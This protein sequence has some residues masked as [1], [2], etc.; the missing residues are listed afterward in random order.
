V[1]QEHPAVPAA[2][3][4]LEVGAEL[5]PRAIERRRQRGQERGEALAFQ[6]LAAGAEQP[7]RRA[8]GLDDPA[9]RARGQDGSRAALDE[10]AQLLLRLPPAFDLFLELGRVRERLLAV[11]C[12]LPHHQAAAGKGGERHECPRPR[13]RLEGERAQ[14]LAQDGT[15]VGRRA[16]R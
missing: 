13:P 11:P 9:V 5:R 15:T 14:H 2:A 6:G 7:P 12:Q 10:H 1:R 16:R 4:A 3:H 8:V